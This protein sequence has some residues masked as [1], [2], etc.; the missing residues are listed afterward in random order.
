MSTF[1]QKIKDT[2]VSLKDIA[3]TL[4]LRV[5]AIFH[6]K[7][8]VVQE[9][10]RSLSTSCARISPEVHTSCS[11]PTKTK[12]N[13][14]KSKSDDDHLASITVFLSGVWIAGCSMFDVLV[15]EERPP[16]HH[17]REKVIR[18]AADRD[19]NLLEAFQR[20]RDPGR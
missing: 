4:V 20:R 15:L 3:A 14:K 8:S 2:I 5:I 10:N 17:I 1:T 11:L 13:K 7:N 9:N 16:E 12:Q 6:L 18:M 19:L